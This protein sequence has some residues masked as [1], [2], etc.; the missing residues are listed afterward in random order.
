MRGVMK[1]VL[2]LRYKRSKVLNHRANLPTCLVQRQQYALKLIE[3]MLSGKRVINIDESTMGQA[4][5]ARKS[6]QRQGV[7]NANVVKPFSH[8]LSL[9]A[10]V[11]T[12]GQVYFAISQSV[13]DSAVFS[14][15][16]VRFAAYLDAEDPHWRDNTVFT[17]DNAAYHKS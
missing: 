5:F 3:I 14:T 8:R 1:S 9:I 13:V 2:R 7:R 11:D 12:Y 15:F 4:V 16:L 6:W 17:I 10:A